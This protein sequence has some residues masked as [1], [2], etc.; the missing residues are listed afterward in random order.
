[1]EQEPGSVIEA[2]RMPPGFPVLRDIKFWT[3]LELD[4]WLKHIVDGQRGILPEQNRFIWRILP[5]PPKERELPPRPVAF[6]AIEGQSVRWTAEELLFAERKRAEHSPRPTRDGS[7]KGLPPARGSHVYAPYNVDL[8]T[9]LRLIHE[10]HP[11]M[12]EVL[13]EVAKMEELGPIHVRIQF[14]LHQA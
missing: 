3:R 10:G 13:S 7:W 5:Q 11:G 4:A 14:D 9:A 6:K 1:M 2:G 8:F 12:R